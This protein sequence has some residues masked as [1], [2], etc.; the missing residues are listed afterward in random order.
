MATFEKR[1][2]R[3][4]QDMWRVKVRRKGASALSATFARLTD[5]RRWAQ[6]T[7]AAIDEGRHFGTK[8]ARKHTLGT[9]IDRYI[10]D[11]LPLKA[12]TTQRKQRQQLLWWREQ[13]GDRL[14]ADMSP[15]VLAEY[16]DSLTAKYALGTAQLYIAVL[17]HVFTVAV[18]DWQWLRGRPVK[19]CEEAQAVPWACA[20]LER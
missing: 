18:R 15:A 3:D 17:S 13:L 10:R 11:V 6:R 19:A 16:R 7:E 9:T 5:A 4:G 20:I 14:L 1:K 12:K 8:E 2:G